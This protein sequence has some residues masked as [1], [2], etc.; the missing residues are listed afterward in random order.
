V[1]PG[2]LAEPLAT[3]PPTLPRLKWSNQVNISHTLLEIS[4][5]DLHKNFHTHK[6]NL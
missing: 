4:N 5:S 3:L 1:L 6:Q 2:R